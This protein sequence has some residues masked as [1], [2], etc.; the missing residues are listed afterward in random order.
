MDPNIPP[1]A[2]YFVRVEIVNEEGPREQ[3]FQVRAPPGL[4]HTDEIAELGKQ[5]ARALGFM[6]TGKAIHN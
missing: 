2:H 4:A 3:L 5:V 6:P 1:L